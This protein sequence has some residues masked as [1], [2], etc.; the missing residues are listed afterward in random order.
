MKLISYLKEG[1]EQLA[2]YIDGDVFDMDLLHPD[3]PNTMSMFLNYW[4][5]ALPMALG[6]EIMVREEKISRKKA[7]PYDS[8]QL[9][10]PVPF[11]A[12]FRNGNNLQADLRQGPS[13]ETNATTVVN[14]FPVFHFSNHHSIQGP[15]TVNCMP[16]QLE[17]LDVEVVVAVVICK[18]GRNIAAA[19]AD[20]FIGGLMLINNFSARRLQQK[21][22][23]QHPTAATGNDFAF[24]TGPWLVT[25]D[26]L[27]PFETTTQDNHTGKSWNLAIQTKLNGTLLIDATSEMLHCTFAEMIERASYGVNLFPGD[28]IGIGPVGKG[29]LPECNRINAS[30]NTG[31]AAKWLKE[32]DVVETASDCLGTLSNT[33]ARE[34]SDFSLLDNIEMHG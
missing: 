28:V 4:E 8:I 9:I 17:D 33:I 18:Q 22:V 31:A 32:G 5:D 13:S 10:A 6:G 25:L 7:V 30:G 20:D 3:L 1:H 29:S 34:E 12:S 27:Q 15:G 19:E 16:D 14:H 26:E 2:A 23:Q 21:A 11:P 24:A